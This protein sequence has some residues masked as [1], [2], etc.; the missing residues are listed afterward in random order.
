MQRKSTHKVHTRIHKQAH[1]SGSKSLDAVRN[2]PVW[3]LTAK[4]NSTQGQSGGLSLTDEE[5]GNELSFNIVNQHVSTLSSAWMPVMTAQCLPL[6]SAQQEN[7]LS[8][9]NCLFICPWTIMYKMLHYS[10]PWERLVDSG[11]CFYLTING[12]E[13][14]AKKAEVN[15]HVWVV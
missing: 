13:T 6:T 1:T 4:F 8:G 7:R 12:A 9:I 2:K 14:K 11:C 10:R 15:A 5:H 3:R